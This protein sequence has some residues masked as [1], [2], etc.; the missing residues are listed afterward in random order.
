METGESPLR[1]ADALTGTRRL[2]AAP[3]EGSFAPLLRARWMRA[4]EGWL[5]KASTDSLGED[6]LSYLE[7]GF[8]SLQAE[9]ADLMLPALC[10]I[11]TEPTAR[12]LGLG[13]TSVGAAGSWSLTDLETES[14][15]FGP[16]RL[17][18][19]GPVTMRSE[20]E[21]AH[22]WSGEG[23]DPAWTFV[24]SGHGWLRSTGDHPP[25][26]TLAGRTVP[27]LPENDRTPRD[28]P[29][30][31]APP[32]PHRWAEI[33]EVFAEA[34]ALLEAAAPEY[35]RW[36]AHVLRA[37]EVVSNDRGSVESGSFPAKP[38]SVYV[39]FPLRADHLA[40]LLVH[41]CAHNYLH[42][43]HAAFPLVDVND[44][45]RYF[46]PFRRTDRPLYGV[47]LALH[48]A[49]NIWVFVKKALPLRPGSGFLV[50][51][52]QDLRLAIEQMLESMD[53]AP[54]FTE[55]GR[56]LFER[57]RELAA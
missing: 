1:G 15:F 42:Q 34:G 10:Q 28:Q 56:E 4:L 39:T 50:Q 3:A 22:I 27:L 53:G 25:V 5:E 26:L 21:A 33:E 17:E 35:A 55:P 38:G 46:S 32:G 37:V 24:R 43:L 49:V 18:L 51:E 12:R 19:A 48:A 29:A 31:G 6:F 8:E 45:R 36:I 47:L 52:E 44:P 11:E 57:L 13:L 9:G 2:V 41:E 7:A 40:T 20:G 30:G 54:G 16:Y 14:A 23:R